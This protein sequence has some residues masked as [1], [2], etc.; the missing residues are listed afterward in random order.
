MHKKD[1][2]ILNFIITFLKLK[3]ILFYYDNKGIIKNYVNLIIIKALE[4]AGIA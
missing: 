1:I 2:R 3:Y 4:N